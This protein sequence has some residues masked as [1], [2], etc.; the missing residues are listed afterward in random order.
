MISEIYLHSLEIN[1]IN[2]N[3][4]PF[5]SKIKYWF[6]Y[7]DDV[8]CLFEGDENESE[9]L[10]EYLNTLNNKI[11]FT[12]ESNTNTINFLDLTISNINNRHEF[13]IY[14]KPTQSDLIIPSQ[15]NHP[16]KYKFSA[17]RS[18]IHRLQN[19]PMSKENYENELNII[20]YLTKKNGY[21]EGTVEKMIKNINKGKKKNS[22]EQDQISK[23][24]YIGIPYNTALNKSIRKTFINSEYKIGFK[25]KNNAFDLINT[26]INRNLNHDQKD[27]F[28]KSGVYEIKCSE[29]DKFYIGQ[30]GR[31]FKLR[32]NEHIQALKSNN[33]TSM[34]SNFAEHLLDKNHSYIS[35]TSN[36]KIL[37]VLNKGNLLDST[38]E[39]YIY[40]EN[41]LNSSKLLNNQLYTRNPIFE[42]I[43]QLDSY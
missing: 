34:K 18:M 38:E 41:K 43:T 3:L 6:R 28:N 22:I 30:T 2:N 16:L 25:T 15:S 42:K 24:K 13:K 5:Y 8:I 35:L 27:K 36:M 37:K 10:L 26:K 33:K 40:K 31:S 11:K 23:E 20:K 19:I 12:K 32:F 29:C 14:R 4:N 7:V 39:Y 9:N 1:Q 17:L 21:K